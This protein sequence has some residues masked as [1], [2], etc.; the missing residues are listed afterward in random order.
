M[1]GLL[2]ID[3]PEGPTSHDVVARV[4]RLFRISRVGHTGTLD[5][6]ATGV[7]PLVLG[8]AT[9][10]AR[11]L[12]RDVKRYEAVIRLG[13]ATD[14]YDRTGEPI[15]APALAVAVRVTRAEVETALERFR[16]TFEQTPPPYSAKKI[17]GVTA[18]RLARRGEAVTPAP[19]TVH[20]SR[21]DLRDVARDVVDE[22]TTVTVALEVECSAGF[23]VR[24]LAHDLGAALGCGG[25]LAALRRTASGEWTL[26]QA[27]PLD[28]CERDPQQAQARILPMSSLLAWMAGVR[29]TDEGAARVRHGQAVRPVDLL[30]QAQAA[31]SAQATLTAQAESTGGPR[32]DGP[33][34]AP[35]SESASFIRLLGPD[36][37]LLALAQP[38]ANG[39]LHPA[40]VLV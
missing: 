1:D 2:I 34:P 25:H 21:L 7:L 38:G 9:R 8:H 14:T 30:E 27:V 26:D 31:L 28:A 11:F 36:G 39:F 29:L 22:D 24:S 4:R 13:Q 32:K 23:Y 19:V 35:E 18:Y 5:P 10:L 37:A 20:V 15:G 16:G 40:L 12:T 33:K 6:M 3:K 17:G